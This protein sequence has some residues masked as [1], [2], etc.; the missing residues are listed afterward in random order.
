MS[1]WKAVKVVVS[2]KASL[3]ASRND[4]ELWYYVA[5]LVP[6]KYTYP[7][8]KEQTGLDRG[9]GLYFWISNNIK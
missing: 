8:S 7:F 4:I 6:C 2:L 9:L 3:T 5:T 1:Q